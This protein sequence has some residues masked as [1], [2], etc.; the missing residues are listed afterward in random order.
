[1]GHKLAYKTEFQGIPISVENAKGSYRHWKDP[2]KGEAGRTYMH[3]AYGYIRGTKGADN[4]GVDV[5]LGPNTDSKVAFVVRQCNPVNGEYDEDKV[6]LGFYTYDEAKMAYLGQYDDPAFF[7]SMDSCNIANLDEC[8]LPQPKDKYLETFGDHVGNAVVKAKDDNE[9]TLPDR[10]FMNPV[11]GADL[12]VGIDTSFAALNK[13]DD[14]KES[15]ARLKK[16]A[17]RLS[18]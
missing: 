8:T 9:V 6:M 5:Y 7:G 14:L 16:A 2:L 15:A 17:A 11:I 13:E 12:G 18:K 1:M 10:A 4:E 3:F